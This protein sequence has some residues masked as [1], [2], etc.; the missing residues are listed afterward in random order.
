MA[1]SPS[2]DAVSFATGPVLHHDLN[3][4]IQTSLESFDVI[5]VPFSAAPALCDSMRP[6]SRHRTRWV[7]LLSDDAN[8]ASPGLANTSCESVAQ[9]FEWSQER[10]SET[11]VGAGSVW[12]VV[13]WWWDGEQLDPLNVG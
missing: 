7:N 2:V 1:G 10:I 13:K 5:P 12:M 3:I 11:H 8:S 6:Q 4:W 9:L